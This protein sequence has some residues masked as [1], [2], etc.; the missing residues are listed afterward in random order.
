LFTHNPSTTGIIDSPAVAKTFSYLS[1]LAV[2][3]ILIWR[4]RFNTSP[5]VSEYALWT[6]GMLLIPSLMWDHYLTQLI[7][8]IALAFALAQRQKARGIVVLGIGL[9]LMAIPYRYDIPLLK[10]GFMTLM[11]P[12]RLY[13]MLVLAWF[14]IQNQDIHLTDTGSTIEKEE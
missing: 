11:M 14:L 9:T 8:A 1:A 6:I 12:I 7:F 13:G 4:T 5:S 10:E 2:L 3:A